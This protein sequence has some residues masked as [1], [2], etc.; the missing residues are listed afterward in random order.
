MKILATERTESAEGNK[1]IIDFSV[2]SVI[3]VAIHPNETRCKFFH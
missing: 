1:G 2:F 3:S